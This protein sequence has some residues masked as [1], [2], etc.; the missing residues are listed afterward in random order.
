MV[1]IGRINSAGGPSPVDRSSR[2]QS[3]R[4]SEASAPQSGDSLSISNRARFAQELQRLVN[5]AE[6]GESAR[7]EV[8]EQA[9]ADLADG[10]LATDQAVSTSA[11]KIYDQL[12]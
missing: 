7:A 3:R 12:A 6:S 10:Q 2:A 8:V 4:T 9:R 11:E 1:E 5:A